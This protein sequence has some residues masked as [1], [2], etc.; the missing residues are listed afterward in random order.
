MN[1]KE[2]TLATLSMHYAYG[3]AM[4]GIYSAIARKLKINNTKGGILF[5]LAVW[6]GSYLGILPA[7]KLH[8]SAKH[9]PWRRNALMI[10]AHVIWGSALAK[11]LQTE[12]SIIDGI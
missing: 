3:S 7:L 12:E 5:G 9:E 11:T 4:G 6:G 10:I 1:A 2:K 8:R